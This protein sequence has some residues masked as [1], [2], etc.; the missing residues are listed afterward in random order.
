MQSVRQSCLS[1]LRSSNYVCAYA[2]GSRRAFSRSTPLYRGSHVQLSPQFTHSI[3]TYPAGSLPNFLEPSSPD[4]IALLSTLN[5]KILLPRHLNKDQEKLVYLPENKARLEADTI[6]ITLGDVTLPLEHIDRNRL[7]NRWKTFRAIIEKSETREDWENVLRV[8]E[9]FEDAGIQLN[10]ERRGLVIR[11]FTL[12]GNQ[13]LTLKLLQRPKASNMRLNNSEV[14][15]QVLRGVHDKAALADWS[16]EETSKALKWAKQVVELMEDPDHHGAHGRTDAT[17]QNDFRGSPMVVALPTEMAAVLAERHGGSSEEVKKFAGRL[18]HTLKQSD[19]TVRLHHQPIFYNQTNTS[20]QSELAR[21]STLSAQ[22]STSFKSTYAQQ[23]FRTTHSH[24]LMT[25][26]Y[27]W[28]ALKTSRKVLGSA[29]PPEAQ[30][31]EQQV[32]KVL[33]EGM[34]QLDVLEDRNELNLRGNA[35]VDHAKDTLQRCR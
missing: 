13:H 27:I 32:E 11:Y 34:K 18:V 8:V 2:N 19:Y 15:V 1:A 20:P 28:H 14:L 5:S 10:S 35:V 31:F 25:L 24:T 6:E 26:I 12:S 16:E 29:A 4:L 3:L 21:I 33:N 7:P 9:G 23:L 30:D 17:A 22:T